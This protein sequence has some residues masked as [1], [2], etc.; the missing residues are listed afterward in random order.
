M[1]FDSAHRPVPPWPGPSFAWATR[2]LRFRVTFGGRWRPIRFTLSLCLLC[3]GVAAVLASARMT[4]TPLGWRAIVIGL[5]GLVAMVVGIGGAM[6]SLSAQQLRR[7]ATRASSAAVPLWG[8]LLTFGVA[9]SAFAAL[10]AVSQ[11][12]TLPNTVTAVTIWI[13]AVALLLAAY[14]F[15]SMVLN[16]GATSRPLGSRSRLADGIRT[17]H[18]KGSVMGMCLAAITVIL[19]AGSPVDSSGNPLIPTL[20]VGAALVA[21]VGW[22][23]RQ[24]Y[25]VSQAQEEMLEAA[26]KASTAA[27]AAGWLQT[28]ESVF[29]LLTELRHLRNVFTRPLPVPWGNR[30]AR[31][32]LVP[33]DYVEDR[34]SGS[35]LVDDDTAEDVFR[36]YSRI[37]IPQLCFITVDYLDLLRSRARANG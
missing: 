29:A 27:E 28:D 9:M 26:T 12:R 22:G 24:L 19:I 36:W 5:G 31:D 7:W 23:L 4:L 13:T 11:P 35:S 18:L 16:A 20:S 10:Y 32:L 37:T 30:A 33:L 3:I 1:K 34:L 25:N 6:H 8:F 14:S 17:L 15:T 2:E 21:V